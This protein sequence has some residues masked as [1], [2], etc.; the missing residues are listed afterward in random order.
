MLSIVIILGRERVYILWGILLLSKLGLQATWKA[1][2]FFNLFN[3]QDK[4]C[5]SISPLWM[6]SELHHNVAQGPLQEWAKPI[7]VEADKTP[8]TLSQKASKGHR[9]HTGADVFPDHKQ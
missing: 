4:R 7:R 3:R 9:L 6:H 5:F 8:P 1:I 2:N